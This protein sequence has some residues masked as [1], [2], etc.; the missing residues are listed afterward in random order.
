M[1]F[2]LSYQRYHD[3]EQ[4]EAQA[5]EARIEAALEKVR[6]ASLSM[7]H[8][9]ELEQVVEVLFHRLSELG[10]DFDGAFDLCF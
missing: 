9:D 5:R 2:Q 1:F 4:A 10:L 7:H 3:I 6:S 8:S